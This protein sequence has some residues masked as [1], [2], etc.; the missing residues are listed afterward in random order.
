MLVPADGIVGEVRDVVT[1]LSHIL[2]DLQECSLV[3]GEIEAQDTCHT[4]LQQAA[5]VVRR[6]WAEEAIGKGF[7][8]LSDMCESRGFV[9]SFFEGLILI[10]ALLDEDSLERS[11][12]VLLFLLREEDLQLFAEEVLRA[13]YAVAQELA[14]GREERLLLVDDAAVG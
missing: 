2:L 10:D 1:K 4:Q 12:E 8:A 3:L 14:D 9:G 11:P 13:L 5:Q 6:H 7:D